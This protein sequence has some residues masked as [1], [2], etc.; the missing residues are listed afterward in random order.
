MMKKTNILEKA[1]P[2]I[3]NV[4]V[5]MLVSQ[6]FLPLTSDAVGDKLTYILVFFIYT[7]VFQFLDEG[8]D[9]GMIVFDTHWQREYKP[10]NRVIYAVLSTASFATLFF[11]IW[12]SLDLFLINMLLLQLPAVLLT[13]ITLNGLVT[14][15]M[16]TIVKN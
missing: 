7:L 6:I 5:V 16:V 10:V 12:F 4:V 9:V 11:K 3:I 8:R 2:A 15:K 14:G 13:G 1:F